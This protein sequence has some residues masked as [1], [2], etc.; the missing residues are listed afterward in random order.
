MVAAVW[1]GF[2]QARKRTAALQVAAPEI[3][4]TFEGDR[5]SAA[6]A[7]QLVTALFKRGSAG[8]P[9]NVM[10]GIVAGFLTSL[11]DYSYT[12]STGK[13]SSTIT[14]TVAAYSQDR[15]LPFF[16][17][18]PENF[19]DRI[20]DAF[21]H[22]DIDFESHPDFSHRYLLRGPDQDEIRNLFSPSLLTFLGGLPAEDKWHIE[23]AGVTLILY[24]AGVEVGAEALRSFLEETSSVA[25][26]F[27]SRGARTS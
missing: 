3:G 24:R 26:A 12:I 18:R 2:V 22:K 4:F 25:K 15:P 27:L 11:F 23:S 1:Y 13:S 6:L 19:L 9:K 7:Q 21:V 14:Q 17:M 20:G 16:E 10:T 8:E 5:T